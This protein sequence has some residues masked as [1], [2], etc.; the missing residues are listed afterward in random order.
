MK[1][2]NATGFFIG[3]M[4][5]IVVGEL[6][7]FFVNVWV[8]TVLALAAEIL[9]VMPNTILQNA[10]KRENAGL[11]KAALKAKIKEA[12]KAEKGVNR[13]FAASFVLAAISLTVL[14]GMIG[15][16]SYMGVM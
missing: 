2:V 11:E 3:G 8:G 4:I 13:L 9:F 12:V 14:V 10:V 1:R 16:G 15:I 6:A 7:Y 5:T